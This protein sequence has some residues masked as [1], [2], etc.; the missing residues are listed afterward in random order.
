MNRAMGAVEPTMKNFAA[1]KMPTGM[2]GEMSKM[3]ETIAGVDKVMGTVSRS[4]GA[5]AANVGKTSAEVIG[6]PQN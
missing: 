4:A 2:N 6:Y 3:V 5:M 1:F